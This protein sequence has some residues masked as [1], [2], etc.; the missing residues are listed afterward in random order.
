MVNVTKIISIPKSC[1]TH[2]DMFTC[3]HTVVC[4]DNTDNTIK[5]VS[6]EAKHCV[7]QHRIHIQV[8]KFKKINKR[9][10]L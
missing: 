3:C 6:I 9:I 4:L 2:I 1:Q 10:R 7:Y 8:L 5:I